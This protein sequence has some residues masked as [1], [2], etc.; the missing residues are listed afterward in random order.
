MAECKKTYIGQILKERE[1]HY[2]PDDKKLVGLE[3]L[4]KIDFSGEIHLS[5]KG[6]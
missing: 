4:N 5:S 1:G 6:S 3:R 2:S